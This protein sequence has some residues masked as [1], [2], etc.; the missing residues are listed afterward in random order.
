MKNK[1][2]IS[3]II[4]FYNA[5]RTIKRCINS[6]LSQTLREI[7]IVCIDDGSH[8]L[9]SKIIE[10]Y[11]I[12]HNNIILFMQENKGAGEARNLG[13]RKANGEFVAFMDSDDYYFGCNVLEE[14]YNKAIQYSVNICGGGICVEKGEEITHSKSDLRKGSYFKIDG[15]CAYKN[16]QY[17]FGFTRFIYNL[18]MLIE[19]EIFFP[20]YRRFEDPPF[21]VKAMNCAKDFYAVSQ[22]I[23]VIAEKN[24]GMQRIAKEALCDIV[25]GIKNVM[26][27]AQNFNY[28]KLY[29]SMIEE[30]L[31]NYL[32]AFYSSIYYGN[33]RLYDMLDALF[34]ELDATLCSGYEN[35]FM[36]KDELFKLGDRMLFE[37]K[38]FQDLAQKYQKIIIYG[39]G[40]VGKTVYEYLQNMGYIGEIEFGITDRKDDNIVLIYDKPIRAMS[41]Y[42]ADKDDC[43]VIIT[44]KGNEKNEM[45]SNAVKLGFRNIYVMEYDMFRWLIGEL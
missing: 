22:D 15:F 25:S 21:L 9:T 24:K 16:Y 32:D 44:V 40:I 2:K 42:T 31:H 29:E 38:N 35:I 19:N 28:S 39:A 7:E 13:I 41:S 43:L 8:D 30:I 1:Y 27:I 6:V 14:L 37:K 10:E 33:V 4:P 11:A 3:V 17:A 12:Q 45:K 5:E 26:A 34:N 36:S 18:S 23:Y 20:A